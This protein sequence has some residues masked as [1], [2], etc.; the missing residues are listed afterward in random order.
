MPVNYQRVLLATSRQPFI[1]LSKRARKSKHR[2][3]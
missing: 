3:L 1:A 2:K